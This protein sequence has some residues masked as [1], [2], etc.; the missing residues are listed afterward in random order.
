VGTEPLGLRIHVE[1]V[2]GVAREIRESLITRLWQAKYDEPESAGGAFV[3]RWVE[4]NTTVAALVPNG[5]GGSGLL[6]LKLQPYGC[7]YRYA[8]V[9]GALPGAS[10]SIAASIIKPSGSSSPLPA[11]ARWCPGGTT[12]AAQPATLAEPG[13]PVPVCLVTK[14]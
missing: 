9:E 1:G 11:S 14:R 6:A 13:E 2:A 5:P 4:G 8:V 10:S 3:E 12:K 7:V